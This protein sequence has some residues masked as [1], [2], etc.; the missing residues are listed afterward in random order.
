[1]AKKDKTAA[2]YA[3]YVKD[4]IARNNKALAYQKFREEYWH[5]RPRAEIEAALQALYAANND[6]R[7]PP[8]ADKNPGNDFS[9]L[10]QGA[11]ADILYLYFRADE[12]VAA[13]VS[14][15]R[16][17]METMDNDPEKQ[18]KLQKIQMQKMA[19]LFQQI[20]PA[21]EHEK[22][23]DSYLKRVL[24]TQETEKFMRDSIKREFNGAA[25]DGKRDRG[26][27]T[28]GIVASLYK[29]QRQYGILLFPPTLNPEEIAH[30]KDL[31]EYLSPFVTQA[32]S[33]LVKDIKGIKEGDII[34]LL[35]RQET[36]GHAAM[37]YGFNGQGEP[38][39]LAFSENA[40]NVSAYAS[41]DGAPRRGIRI[42]IK[43]F[44]EAKALE[45]ERARAAAHNKKTQGGR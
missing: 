26:N 6:Y 10:I 12:R 30:P 42:D 45:Q 38:L 17:S 3:N 37:C 2:L 28:K 8:P 5:K 19:V 35:H 4:V 33:G 13:A 9:C 36:P 16:K 11:P 21:A 29:L 40:K 22:Y 31:A 41:K 14:G 44:I 1:M 24:A 23:M 27:C 25:F 20:V 15:Y 7:Q 18:K 32:D 34:M 39:L 43:A